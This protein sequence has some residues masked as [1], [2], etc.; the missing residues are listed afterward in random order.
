MGGKYLGCKKSISGVIYTWDYF[1]GGAQFSSEPFF[2]GAIDYVGDISSERP[3][4]SE[5]ISKGILSRGNY[6]WGNCPEVIILGNCTGGNNPAGNFPGGDFP[7]GNCP[8]TAIYEFGCRNISY[9]MFE[10]SPIVYIR[11]D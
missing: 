8:D 9:L 1:P 4:S 11:K 7:W 2:R 6:I 5:S 10:S 3:F